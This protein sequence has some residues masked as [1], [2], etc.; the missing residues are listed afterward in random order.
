[1]SSVRR[2]D[3][4]IKAI[5]GR[6]PGRWLGIR[7]VAVFAAIP[8]VLLGLAWLDGPTGDPV[9]TPGNVIQVQR[10][11]PKHSEVLRT[12]V[13]VKLSDGTLVECAGPAGAKVGDTVSLE[14]EVSRIL[15]RR[16]F[17]C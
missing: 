6:L 14:T 17:R 2:H 12:V 15:R 7:T 4:E 16:T 10:G 5:D 3:A 13:T 11:L 8:P 9:R 1:M